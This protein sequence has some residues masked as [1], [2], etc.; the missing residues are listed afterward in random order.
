MFLQSENQEECGESKLPLNT[1]YIAQDIAGICGFVNFNYTLFKLLLLVNVAETNVQR[2]FL[3]V[4]MEIH[5]RKIKTR[6]I[7]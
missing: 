6:K 5:K 2:T 4:K 1:V 7:F 3:K